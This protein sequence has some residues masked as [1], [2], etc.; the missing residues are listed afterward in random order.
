MQE[1][2]TRRRRGA[3]TRDHVLAA[4]LALVDRDGLEEL[5]MRKLA[6]ELDVE[7]M[8]LYK[9]VASKEDLLAGLADRI[10][11]E[12][13]SAA[14]PGDDWAT[15]L[16]A[17]G[18]AI[19]DAVRAHP[20]AVPVLVSAQ[21]F[22]IPMLEVIATQFEHLPAGWP[23]QPAAASALCTVT[24]F[25]LGSAVAE[26]AYFG[27][28]DDHD[29]EAAERQRLLRV[30]RALPPDT[31]DRLVDAAVACCACDIGDVLEAG[32]DL[33]I[34]GGQ[35]DTAATSSRRRRRVQSSRS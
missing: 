30:V 31:P 34:R 14:P 29:R 1:P 15:W 16:R 22:P 5:S 25:A 9:R 24:A 32:L 20:N 27:T 18:H 10:W 8:S 17:Y 23:P 6:A 28:A 21:V 33:I 4:A 12:I 19:R 11:N 35:P 26:R 7:T 2:R 13:A 3:L